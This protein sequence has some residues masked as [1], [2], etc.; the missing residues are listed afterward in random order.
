LSHSALG[1]RRNGVRG[2]VDLLG[3]CRPLPVAR[4][5]PE[6]EVLLASDRA[7]LVEPAS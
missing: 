1:V 2:P 4:T 5:A 3:L 6:L 7:Y